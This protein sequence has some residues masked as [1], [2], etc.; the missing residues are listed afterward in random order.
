MFQFWVDIPFICIA[1]NANVVCFDN[2]WSTFAGT[3]PHTLFRSPL[4]CPFLAT[5]VS[6]KL[7][8]AKNLDQSHAT[9]QSSGIQ[10]SP[11]SKDPF[12]YLKVSARGSSSNNKSELV[13]VNS[14]TTVIASHLIWDVLPSKPPK[15]TTRQVSQM[16]RYLCRR[17][18]NLVA[19]WNSCLMPRDTDRRLLGLWGFELSVERRR[20]RSDRMRNSHLPRSIHGAR[21]RASNGGWKMFRRSGDEQAGRAG[22]MKWRQARVKYDKVSPL[23]TSEQ[24][25]NAFFYLMWLFTHSSAKQWLTFYTH[26]TREKVVPITNNEF[27]KCWQAK[28]G[29]RKV[30]YS[31]KTLLYFI[32]MK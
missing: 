6:W 12:T 28:N 24:D 9:C 32:E 25:Y 23:G 8:A 13:S 22:D 1:I 19:D 5:V 27:S 18:T 14:Y 30:K 17:R 26:I 29:V 11:F 31:E 10:S 2:Q 21:T 20:G 4:V 16:E 15:G 7:G 3:D